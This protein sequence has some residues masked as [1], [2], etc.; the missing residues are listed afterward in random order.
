MCPGLGDAQWGHGLEILGFWDVPW[1]W[2]VELGQCLGLV[3]AFLGM[4]GGVSAWRFLGCSMGSV[5]GALGMFRN[6]ACSFGNANPGF[7]DV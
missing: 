1:G 4:L 6:G 3:P 5:P 2:C 7:G